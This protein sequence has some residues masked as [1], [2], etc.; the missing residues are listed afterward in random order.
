MG[1]GAAMKSLRTLSNIL[2]VVFLTLALLLIFNA[3]RELAGALIIS[4]AILIAGLLI[5]SA[6]T[7][8]K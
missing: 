4:A 3:E 2:S 8:S 7:E 6:I 5:A 1:R